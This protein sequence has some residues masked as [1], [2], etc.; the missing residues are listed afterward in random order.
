M[1]VNCKGVQRVIHFGPSKSLECY[2]QESGRCGRQGEPSY[3][4]LLYNGITLRTADDSMKEY[5][6]DK[7]SCRR[8]ALLKPFDGKSDVLAKP[9]G[10][11]C[12]D[13][14]TQ[15]CKCRDGYHCD[16]D[17]FL[18]VGTL[19]QQDEIED[20]TRNVTDNQREQLNKRLTNAQINSCC[21]FQSCITTGQLPNNTYALWRNS[22]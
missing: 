7:Y 4:V 19:D 6:K 13:K 1:G 15:S 16:V 20:G 8:E 12:C 3:A 17:V 10:H 2:I 18:P 22:S 5:I 21:R 9:T 14:C 11:N